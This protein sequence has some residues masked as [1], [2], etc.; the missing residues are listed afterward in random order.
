MGIQMAWNDR[1]RTLSLHLAPGSRMLS[2]APRA[3]AAQLAEGTRHVTF[4]GEPVRV[5][6]QS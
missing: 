3:I 2:P 4:G 6:F 1:R 5:S